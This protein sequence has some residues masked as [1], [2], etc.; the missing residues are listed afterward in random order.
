[1]ETARPQ[2]GQPRLRIRNHRIPAAH[3]RPAPPVDVQRQKPAYLRGGRIKITIAAPH[4]GSHA[5]GLQAAR[6]DPRAGG[7]QFLA[8]AATSRIGRAWPVVAGH[9]PESVPVGGRLQCPG[10]FSLG[11]GI[12]NPQAAGHDRP[13]EWRGGEQPVR[14]GPG[15]GAPTVAAI[16]V[17]IA[18]VLTGSSS[19]ML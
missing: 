1:M 4:H 10:E 8:E 6:E 19:V 16:A 3:L 17:S 9:E 7:D 15:A 12:A 18:G 13:Y 5:G 14:H 11:L 2:P